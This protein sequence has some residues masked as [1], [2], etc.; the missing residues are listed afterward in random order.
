MAFTTQTFLFFFFPIC[1]LVY[2]AAAF[3]EKQKFFHSFFKKIRLT[4]I[5]LIGIGMVF[6]AWA[7][8]DDVLRLLVYIFA[9]YVAGVWIAKTRGEGS[10]LSIHTEENGEKRVGISALLLFLFVSVLVFILAKY[11]YA[12]SF[13]KIWN[14]LFKTDVSSSS[15]MVPLGLSFLTFSAISYLADIARGKAEA[16][17][18]IDCMLYLSFFPKV[19]SGPIV[20]WQDFEGMGERRIDLENISYGILRM[21]SGFAKKLIIADTFGALISSATAN[22]IDTLTALGISL[23]YMLQIYYDFS[24]YSDIALGL[25][26]ILGYRFKENFDYPYLSSS[27][28]EF[29]R[30]WHISLGTWFREYVYIPL[31]GNKKGKRKQILNILIVF[32]LTGIWHGVGYAFVAWGLIH[33]ACN[34][35]ER[36]MS[37]KTFYQKTPRLVK[38]L[39]TMTILFFSW[40]LFRIGSISE[41]KDYILLAIGLRHMENIP[42]TW[43]YYFDKRI[44]L[45]VIVAVLGATLFGLPRV[46]S[47]RERAESTRVGYIGKQLALLAL[48]AISVLFMVNSTYNPFLYFQF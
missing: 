23:L 17:S 4:D 35:A 30:R 41:T 8:F 31:G 12:S 7:C 11:K 20:L 2:Y 36:W 14:F 33:G 43:Q 47:L 40:Q 24:G 38:W 48:F 15:V 32:F 22:A 21:M 6:Y 29:W 9:V 13:L 10:Y 42:Y 1:M 5:A 3:A 27:I 19:I 25:S 37:N 39:V 16:G 34:A 28:T 18:L 44:V 46:R 26:A 45:L